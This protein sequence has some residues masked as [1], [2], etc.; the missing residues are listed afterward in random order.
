MPSERNKLLAALDDFWFGQSTT[1]A[2]GVLRIALGLFVLHILVISFP[3]W[4]RFYGDNATMPL[5]L[6]REQ[7]I[8]PLYPPP[9]VHAGGSFTP[10]LSAGN[11]P[12]VHITAT[13][14]IQAP[15]AGVS[16]MAFLIDAAAEITTVG[17]T[18]LGT[19]GGGGTTA[20][21]ATICR[22]EGGAS[23]WA[24]GPAA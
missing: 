8:N 12:F 18:E 2:L 20:T 21:Q 4:Q 11:A 23:Y 13:S 5:W 24:W 9:L 6:L 15:S 16:F 10:N 19:R 17:Y 22:D 14:T 1:E 3:N 7:G